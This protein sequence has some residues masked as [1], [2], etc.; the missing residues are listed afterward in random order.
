[1]K[2]IK[3]DIGKLLVESLT[4]DQ[5]AAL[6]DV[7][8]STGDM[9]QY[10]DKF[11]KADPDMAETVSKVLKMDQNK[12]RKPSVGRLVSDQGKIGVKS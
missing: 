8:F 9:D 5:I 7:L 12:G 4:T 1:M 3:R 11:K 10:A 6:L 2:R